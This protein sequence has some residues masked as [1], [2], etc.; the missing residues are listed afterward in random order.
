VQHGVAGE[1]LQNGKPSKGGSQR[2]KKHQRK[3]K[4]GIMGEW[5]NLPLKQTFF[6][7]IQTKQGKKIAMG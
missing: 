3:E 1:S 4:G 6:L 2:L 7:K 5:K